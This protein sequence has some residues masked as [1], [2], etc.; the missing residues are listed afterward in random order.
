SCRCRTCRPAGRRPGAGADPTARL[1][2]IAGKQQEI[3]LEIEAIRSKFDEENRLVREA[4]RLEEF[5]STDDAVVPLAPADKTG[6]GTN[7]APF[8]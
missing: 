2:E 4:D 7:V 6:D 3:V 8:P 5:F 1:G